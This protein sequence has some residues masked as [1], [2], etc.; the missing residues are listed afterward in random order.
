MSIAV[1]EKYLP[2]N[3]LPYLKK[4]FATHRIHIKIT[5]DRNSK[6]GD[7]RK[8]PDS[9]HQITI[10]STLEPQLFFFVLA[11]E[12]AHLLAFENYGNRISPH[13]AEW[14]KT[15]SDMIM[16]S[17]EVYEKSLQGILKKF[18]KSPKANY[19]A[20][21]DL[22]RYFHKPKTDSNELLLELLSEGDHFKYR[23]EMYLIYEKNKKKYLCQNLSNGRKYYFKSVATVEKIFQ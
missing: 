4:W 22:V 8:L 13:G 23:D 1:L 15:F 17:L 16:E 3:S 5:R 10:N 6:L 7:Y 18:A 20:S 9:S 14:K 12:L 11:H 19:L 21:P 2:E